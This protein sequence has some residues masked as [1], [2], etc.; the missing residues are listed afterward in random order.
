M[1]ALVMARSCDCCAD[2]VPDAAKNPVIPHMTLELR[3]GKN[4]VFD[5]PQLSAPE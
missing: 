2:L 4:E 1:I 5:A 3:R